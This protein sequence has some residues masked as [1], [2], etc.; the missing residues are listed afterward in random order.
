M[1]LIK[2]HLAI[3]QYWPIFHRIFQDNVCRHTPFYDNRSQTHISLF[4]DFPLNP[5]IWHSGFFVVLLHRNSFLRLSPHDLCELSRSHKLSIPPSYLPQKFQLIR[6]ACSFS[7]T[8]HGSR[9]FSVSIFL[10]IEI[11]SNRSFDRRSD[12]RFACP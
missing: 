6:S 10:M 4:S 9:N 12:R 5:R 8:S 3:H 7:S 2:N 11:S 1:T